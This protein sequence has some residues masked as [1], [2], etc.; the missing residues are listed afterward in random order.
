MM[1]VVDFDFQIK[2]YQL[3]MLNSFQF[4]SEKERFITMRHSQSLPCL[5][6]M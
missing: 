1:I 2:F 4:E 5:L 6:D 3:K